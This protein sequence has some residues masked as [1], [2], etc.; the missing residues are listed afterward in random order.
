[1][2]GDGGGK[3]GKEEEEEEEVMLLKGICH[4]LQWALQLHTWQQLVCLRKDRKPGKRCTYQTM[5]S[6]TVLF[7]G[8]LHHG[9]KIAVVLIQVE[10]T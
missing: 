9:D 10:S 6:F 5:T 4:L 3:E 8:H 7:P 1:M 2:I